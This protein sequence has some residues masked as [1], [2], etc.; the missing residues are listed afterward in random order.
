MIPIRNLISSLHYQGL[1]VKAILSKHGE[2]STA[3]FLDKSRAGALTEIR[4]GTIVPVW[5]QEA[6]IHLKFEY[7][8][9]QSAVQSSQE[10]LKADLKLPEP[11]LAFS[12]AGF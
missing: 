1:V 4:R 12:F 11:L 3:F 10:G 9:P 6:V 7:T 8:V 2:N 5:R